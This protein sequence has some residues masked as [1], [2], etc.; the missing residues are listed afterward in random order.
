[1]K[2]SFLLVLYIT[3]TIMLHAQ[4]QRSDVVSMRDYEFLAPEGWQAQNNGDHIL[5]QN[6][7]SGCL[8]R[9]VA[10]QPSS[11]DLEQDANAVFDLMYTGWQY[12]N[13]GTDQYMLSKGYLSKGLEYC[14]KEAA[15]SNA[16][17]WQDGAA[18]IVRAGSQIVIISV[19]HNSSMM[20]HNDCLRKYN[21]WRRFF[22][23]F[24]VKNATLPKA[25]EEDPAKR[26]V[27]LWKVVAGMVVSDYIFAANGHYQH[28]GAIG[29]SST[30]TDD[31][32]KYTHYTSYSFEGDGNY[33]IGDKRLMLAKK[34]AASE[35]IPIRFEKVNHSDNRWIDRLYMLKTDVAGEYEV[36]YEKQVR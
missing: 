9:V 29:T 14:M 7:Q 3:I 13:S 5:F 15:V 6:M 28:G 12:R 24:T 36:C 20:A 25:S 1:M 16:N 23:S 10:P 26:I 2:K 19:R 21:T 8:I 17:E 32:Y 33:S 11:G 18:L 4:S 30:T 31:H 22:N 27:G 34:G 35:V